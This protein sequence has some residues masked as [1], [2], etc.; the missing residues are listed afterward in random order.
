MYMLGL[1]GVSIREFLTQTE[2]IVRTAKSESETLRRLRPLMAE[3][4]AT[5]NS[6]PEAA[7][8]QRK[9][10]FANSLIY[11]P[12]DKAFSVNAAVWLPGQTTPIH[13]HLTWAMVGLYEG[14][15]RESIFR[16]TDDGSN[17][18][19]ARLKKVNERVNRKG[20]ITTL[21]SSGIHRIDNVSAT[22]SHSIH[23]YGLDIGNEER[24]TYDPVTGEVGKFVS[25]YCN[26]LRDE[27]LD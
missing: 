16:R 27:E 13:D 4:L 15:E 24:H 12:D 6:V 22:P 9:D 10:R 8:K 18:K 2:G 20:H 25:G 1:S 11:M 5:P 7:F 14:E 3:L 23:I 26:V 19:V 17:P 21:G